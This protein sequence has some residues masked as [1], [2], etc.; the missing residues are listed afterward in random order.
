MSILAID[1]GTTSTRALHVAANGTWT[2]LLSLPH[3]QFY[4]AP[5]WVEHE[6]AELLANLRAC[7]DAGA[8]MHPQA[9]GIAN[10]GESC[11]AWDARTGTAI[12]PVIVWQDNRTQ[13]VTEMLARDGTAQMVH[14]RAGLPLDPYFSASK[15]G[16]IMQHI[17]AAAALAQQG[18]LRL[19]TTDAWFRD[20][21]TGRHETDVTT[22]SRT[23]LMH[24]ATCQ[25]DSN[26]CALFGVPIDALPRIT[27]TTGTLGLVACGTSG[28]ATAGARGL[29]TTG[30]T[31]IPLTTSV[32]DQQ[33]A[34]Y[35]HGCRLAGDAKITFGTGAFA[36]SVTGATLPQQA[37]GAGPLPTVAWQKA[38]EPVT[39]A[40]DGGVYAASS[41]VNWARG[42]GL[43]TDWAQINHF[44]GPPAISRG[45]VFVPA[46]AG[47][48]C[49]HWDR[50]ARGAWLGLGLDT[51]AQ[52]MMQALLE[53]V[54]FRTGE[55]ID[56]MAR[57]QPLRDP[58]SLDGGMVANPWFCQFLANR[59]GRQLIV[60]DEAELTA[61]GTAALAAHG[62]GLTVDLPRKG[63]TITPRP[64][65]AGWAT[66]FT[67]ARDAVQGFGQQ[68]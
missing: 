6:P 38:G 30:T 46:L 51:T 34:L 4:P 55:V 58:I 40:L 16:W 60:S 43:F 29:A 42:L 33:A 12:S 66:R 9:I 1:Q 61:I 68:G 32:T 18:Y 3:R 62:A 52:N 28:L 25:W 64:Q 14:D 23:S 41:A 67:A 24:L 27:A 5:G 35:G 26:L 20:R 13:D 65:P 63:R 57:V 50:Q 54:V 7:I 37:M 39:Y 47:L 15:L 17:P 31:Q 59:L 19:G 10:Q 48:A 21:L 2:A 56:S 53:G 8:A 36:L 22:A 49:P 45:L 44:D 11:L